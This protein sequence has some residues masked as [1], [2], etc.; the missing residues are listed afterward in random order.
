MTDKQY[1]KEK[2]VGVL[3]E[4]KRFP[5][6]SREQAVKY[7]HISNEMLIRLSDLGLM[8]RFKIQQQNYY[9][10]VFDKDISND[11]IKKSIMNVDA[12]YRLKPLLEENV[13]YFKFENDL[14]DKSL[15]SKNV[16]MIGY[17]DLKEKPK[18]Y[19]Y[20]VL[21]PLQNKKDYEKI[22]DTMI[23]IYFKSE[24]EMIIVYLVIH[25]TDYQDV[26]DYLN[27][28]GRLT[29][30]TI[31]RNIQYETITVNSPHIDCLR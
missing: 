6:W 14:E 12:Y 10:S 30:Y 21:K 18:Y 16:K 20:F 13:V 17:Q 15:I 11:K 25:S 26:L 27:N 1:Y 3:E 2:Y 31:N 4:F 29:V 22:I 24:T 9:S 5:V 28:S 8:N 23:D 19:F 7:L